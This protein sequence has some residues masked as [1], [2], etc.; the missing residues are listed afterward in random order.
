MTST[1]SK[2]RKRDVTR[3]RVIQAAIDCIYEEGFHSANTNRIAERAGVSWGVLQY[4]FGDKDSLL[5]AVLETIFNHFTLSLSEQGLQQKELKPRLRALIDKVWAM[6]SQ[7]DYRVSVAILRN[8]GLSPNSGIDG[9]SYLSQWAEEIGQLWDGLFEDLQHAPETNQV[10]RRLLFSTLRG[11]ADELIP[12]QSGEAPPMD[13]ELTG[14][15]DAIYYLL[16]RDYIPV[17]KAAPS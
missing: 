17:S 15:T 8:A 1:V 2:P 11:L 7:P 3:A 14:L 5:Q 9:S 13:A 6:V 12:T 16:N 10:A 4:H